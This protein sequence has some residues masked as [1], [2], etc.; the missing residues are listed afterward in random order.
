MR[1]QKKKHEKIAV[2]EKERNI[3]CDEKQKYIIE[4]EAMTMKTIRLNNLK[5]A[6][7]LRAQKEKCK[8]DAL[9]NYLLKKKQKLLSLEE[10]CEG[11]KIENEELKDAGSTM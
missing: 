8:A 2:I 7:N 1:I 10:A 3:E 4:N 6:A 9:T 11:L 5:N